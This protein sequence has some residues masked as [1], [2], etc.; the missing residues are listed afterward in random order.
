MGR[1]WISLGLLALH[2][3]APAQDVVGDPAPVA[4]IGQPPAADNIIILPAM[5]PV[6]LTIME[7]LN[8]KT[9]KIGQFFSIRLVEPV[10]FDNRI[11][12]P[13]G[14]LGKGEVIH[15]AKARAAG[16]A[17]ELIIAA[18][19]LEYQGI[20]IPLRT[21]KYGEA[22]T[23]KSNADEAAALGIAVASPLVL[24]VTGG[25]VDVPAGMPATAKLAADVRIEMQQQ[26][27]PQEGKP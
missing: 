19:Y 13:A 3:A 26:N 5:T 18:R 12:V 2:N 9:S 21:L 17:G 4:A 25:Q 16:K 27:S 10:M 24:F 14:T 8:S 6:K 23:G 15:A 11:V 7:S 20:Q 1:I 22:A